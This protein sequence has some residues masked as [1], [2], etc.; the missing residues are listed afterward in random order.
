MEATHIYLPVF[1]IFTT[2]VNFSHSIQ[3]DLY[4]QSNRLIMLGWCAEQHPNYHSLYLV[5]NHPQ[6]QHY[7]LIR[8]WMM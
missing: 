6:K 5:I 2:V 7:Y 4:S 1:T 3:F 8:Y